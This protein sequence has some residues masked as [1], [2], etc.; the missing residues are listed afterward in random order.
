MI[1]MSARNSVMVPL[2]GSG[3]GLLEKREDTNSWLGLSD[4]M[5]LVRDFGQGASDWLLLD[6]DATPHTNHAS[7]P[8]SVTM[9]LVDSLTVM[10]ERLRTLEHT[11]N[12]T[13]TA[14]A[15][16]DGYTPGGGGGGDPDLSKYDVVADV[17]ITEGQLVYISSSNH[18]DLAL[19]LPSGND[20]DRTRVAAMCLTGASANGTATIL[21][22]GSVEKSDWTSITGTTYL[23]P[24]KT[25]FLRDDV[26]GGMRYTPPNSSIQVIVRVGKAITTTTFDIE[27][28]QPI[29]VPDNSIKLFSLDNVLTFTDSASTPAT[30]RKSSDSTMNLSHIVGLLGAYNK[31]VSNSMSLLDEAIL[32][33]DGVGD[34]TMAMTDDAGFNY[35]DM[36]K[37]EYVGTDRWQAFEDAVADTINVSGAP[38][39]TVFGSLGTNANKWW[40]AVLAPNGTDIYV[41]PYSQT[42]M[43]KINT[44][45][46]T[47]TTI[48]T[49]NG[50][51][52]KWAGGVLAP[53]GYIYFSPKAATSILKL[54]PSDDSTSN[55]TT[56]SN[57]CFAGCHAGDGII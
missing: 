49:Y 33:W 51:V 27:I 48:G 50:T 6:S 5:D 15:S 12:L 47:A 45:N 43:L 35:A 31:S 10:M 30:L 39:E 37:W 44:S 17:D 53:N 19:A 34:D 13:N 56:T 8:G 55:I 22:E 54:D 40:G 4:S 16:L 3:V 28:A 52:G 1:R 20:Y 38:A 7:D 11:L 42:T 25:Y 9:A 36:L 46:N 32:T 23:I 2:S 21:T 26:L 57:Q 18:V 29:N 14:H 24:G 41:P